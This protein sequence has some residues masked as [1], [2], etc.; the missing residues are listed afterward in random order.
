MVLHSPGFPDSPAGLIRHDIFY[1]PDYRI[2]WGAFTI[3][4]P[5]A[6]TDMALRGGSVVYLKKTKN[7]PSRT[8]YNKIQLFHRKIKSFPIKPQVFYSDAGM[9]R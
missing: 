1:L 2:Y 3:M 7:I 8:V 5:A 4:S 9:Q 6:A